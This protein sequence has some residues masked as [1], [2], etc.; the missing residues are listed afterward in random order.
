MQDRGLLVGKAAGHVVPRVRPSAVSLF[1]TGSLAALGCD[2]HPHPRG[3]APCPTA[4]AAPAPAEGAPSNWAKMLQ[5]R[6]R[7]A[8]RGPW[9]PSEG[10]NICIPL[11]S[12]RL[13]WQRE[14]RARPSPRRPP[15]SGG[16][17]WHL[18]THPL[19][20]GRSAAPA[21]LPPAPSWQ[22]S[23]PSVFKGIGRNTELFLKPRRLILKSN[24]DI[25]RLRFCYVSLALLVCVAH[26][27]LWVALSLRNNR[28]R[29][30]NT[31]V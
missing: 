5:P 18:P 16:C 4:G 10:L 14:K 31:V 23:L 30:K 24:G 21:P 27:V 22:S 15:V 1:G 29:S 17:C 28:D 19:P 20:R 2:A 13:R 6:P 26:I 25:L 8:R 7:K 9:Q 3:Q 11:V 12:N